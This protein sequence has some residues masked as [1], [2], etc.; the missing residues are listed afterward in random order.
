M[1]KFSPTKNRPAKNAKFKHYRYADFLLITLWSKYCSHCMCVCVCVCV[2]FARQLSN[3]MTLD[4]D[5][6]H[7]GSFGPYLGQVGSL[8]Q[9]S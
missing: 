5:I 1:D 6:E 3:K 4:L 9:K 8:R 2:V 7:G